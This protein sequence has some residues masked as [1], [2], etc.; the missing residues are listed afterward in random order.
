MLLKRLSEAIGVSSREQE[1]RDILREEVGQYASLRTDALGDLIA[2]KPGTGPKVMLA[3]HMDEVGLMITSIEKN[4]TL[5]FKP[6]GAIDPRV[7]VAKQVLVGPNKIPGVIGSKPIHLQRP[8]ERN[9]PI[10]L[11]DMGIDIGAK[12]EAAKEKMKLELCRLCHKFG[13]PGDLVKGRPSMTGWAVCSGR[14]APYRLQVPVCGAFTVQEKWAVGG[15]VVAYDVMPDVAIV[16][17]DHRL[18]WRIDPHLHAPASVRTSHYHHGRLCHRFRKIVDR[19]VR[20]AELGILISLEKYGRGTVRV[21]QC[22]PD[23]IPW[24][25]LGAL[26]LHSF[27]RFHR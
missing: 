24:R 6:V 4:G 5:K 19:L 21:N 9:H 18:R 22:H 3:A 15:R 14:G 2:E 10:K 23:R 8:D 16:L 1:V 7:L 12:D 11:E 25:C 17:E 13:L 27:A 26:P 20:V